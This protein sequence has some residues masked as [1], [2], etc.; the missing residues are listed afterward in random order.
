MTLR[1][2][3]LLRKTVLFALE[4]RTPAGNVIDLQR[5]AGVVVAAEGDLITVRPRRGGDD[6]VLPFDPDWFEPAAE[7]VYKLPQTGDLVVNPD[8]MAHIDFEVVPDEDAA[9]E[10]KED[11]AE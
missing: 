5:F 1:A 2:D 4:I 6:R 9:E 8:Y 11:S 3:D 7:K 10:E